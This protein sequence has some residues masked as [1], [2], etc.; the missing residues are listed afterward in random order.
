MDT[1][2]PKIEPKD[3]VSLLKEYVEIS[4]VSGDVIELEASANEE[5]ARKRFYHLKLQSGESIHLTYGRNLQD[6]F[7]RTSAF[8]QIMPEHSCKP[9]FCVED[10]EFHLFGQEFF[11]GIPI[12][13]Y[14]EFGSDRDQEV[15]EILKTLECKLERLERPSTKEAY[16]KELGKAI[17]LAL[18]CKNF[19]D[20]DRSFLDKSLFN[21]LR[22]TL[23]NPRPTIRWSPGDLAARN[24][25][26]SNDG[27][28]R[29]IDCE[30]AYETHF[31]EEDWIRLA[32]FSEPPLKEL[33]FIKKRVASCA[34][35]IEAFHWCRQISLTRLL[36]SGTSYLQCVWMDLGNFKKSL[37]EKEDAE[38]L[39]S[40]IGHGLLLTKDFEEYFK[41]E[42]SK[43]Q[44][45]FTKLHKETIKHQGTATKLH[46]ETVKHQGT[47]T[48]LH[49]E[50]VKHQGTATKL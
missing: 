27:G 16:A 41:T 13:E 19:S 21:Y 44:E 35:G 25:L 50:T 32:H 17:D 11:H 9:L 18:Q 28:F 37:K 4:Q 7:E 30:F 40:L 24:V 42:S 2:T 29:I 10:G 23:I 34:K 12:D 45:T 33:D 46:E 6:V 36:H 48:K 31:H 43:H 47:A 14:L 22:Q 8:H 38:S 15:T 5:H 3:L 1:F 39:N 49:Q 20:H 26:V